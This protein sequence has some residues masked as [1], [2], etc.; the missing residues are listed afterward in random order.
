M[1]KRKEKTGAGV[2]CLVSGNTEPGIQDA[3]EDRW[4]VIAN[5]YPSEAI[6]QNEIATPM[7]KHGT[8]NDKEQTAGR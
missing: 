4:P 2:W 1:P 8:R 7:M 6:P 5:H 3:G